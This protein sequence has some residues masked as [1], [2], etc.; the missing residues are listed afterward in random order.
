MGVAAAI[1]VLVGESLASV[2]GSADLAAATTIHVQGEIPLSTTKVEARSGLSGSAPGA[3]VGVAGALAVNATI[4]DATALAGSLDANGNDLILT[5]DST[6]DSIARALPKVDGTGQSIGVGASIAMN[7]ADHTTKAAAE[8]NATISAVDDLT[9]D[10]TSHHNLTTEAESAAEG[11]IAVAAVVAAAIGIED[12]VAE[13]GPGSSVNLAGDL[14]STATHHGSVHTKAEGDA[15]GTNE[16]AV[17]VAIAV[18][19]LDE[20]TASRVAGNVVADN[21]TLG[22]HQNW[23]NNAE[24]LASAKGAS[25][26]DPGPDWHSNAQLVGGNVLATDHGAR[27]FGTPLPSA[28][29]L[30]N[31]AGGDSTSNA[32]TA[33]GSLG[34]AA[35]LAVNVSDSINEASIDGSANIAATGTVTVEAITDVDSPRDAQGDSVTATDSNNIAAAVGLNVPIVENLARP[36]TERPSRA[37]RSSCVR[38]PRAGKPTSSSP[39]A[40]PPVAAPA[41]WAWPVRRVSILSISRPK[42]RRPVDRCSSRTAGCR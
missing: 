9:L 2:G 26:S 18:N 10:A 14:N 17:G 23:S 32:S 13:L 19:Y 15:E 29:D 35:A 33:A 7:I 16:A 6:T 11:G 22:S 27:P 20:D 37:T 40:Q 1:G 38:R 25:Q 4:A 24:A 21:V 41:T 28:S 12:T 30:A 36:K 31:L 8:N 34:V 42:P 5:A 39:G 3:D